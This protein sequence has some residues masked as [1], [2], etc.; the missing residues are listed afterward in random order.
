MLK[1]KKPILEDQF[2]LLGDYLKDVAYFIDGKMSVWGLDPL[3][4]HIF[5]SR[6]EQEQIYAWK[7]RA[8]IYKNF[9]EIP[10][11]VHQ[12]WRAF[13]LRI[14][15]LNFNQVK[16]LYVKVNK[17]FPYGKTGI[18]TLVIEPHNLW[19]EA[20]DNE[21]DFNYTLFNHIHVQSLNRS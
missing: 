1:F 19:L 5:R 8:G 6:D 2:V 4:T 7:V 9:S 13:D 16:E 11:S 18:N 15:G 17:Y 3:V 21:R 12:F 10:N 20:L 14:Y